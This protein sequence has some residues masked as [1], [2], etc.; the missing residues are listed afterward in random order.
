VYES[1]PIGLR[2]VPNRA[3][4]LF[5][6]LLTLGLAKKSRIGPLLPDGTRIQTTVAY[7]FALF[8]ATICVVWC[9]APSILFT[10]WLTFIGRQQLESLV[11]SAALI[12]VVYGTYFRSGQTK[13]AASLKA[14]VS[15]ALLAISVASV[16]RLRQNRV[17]ALTWHTA[18]VSAAHIR[19]VAPR[20]AS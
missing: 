12:A 14:G 19:E 7:D 18:Q 17:L 1:V 15:L 2:Y 13:L 8:I 16:P 3:M 11:P 6:F 10:L 20:L 4:L 9:L 5:P